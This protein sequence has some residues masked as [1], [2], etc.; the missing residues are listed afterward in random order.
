MSLVPHHVSLLMRNVMH[1][2]GPLQRDSWHDATISRWSTILTIQT[3]LKHHSK[4]PKLPQDMPLIP[5]EHE[6]TKKSTSRD[7]KDQFKN[8]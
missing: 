5:P 2:A 4:N 1:R 3:C 6:S 7:R 8:Y